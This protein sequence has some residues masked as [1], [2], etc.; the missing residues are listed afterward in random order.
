MY[1]SENWVELLIKQSVKQ[2]NQMD[3][4]LTESFFSNSVLFYLKQ[5]EELKMT[6]GEISSYMR[7]VTYKMITIHIN[8]DS[9]LCKC[10]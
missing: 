1:K 4:V 6:L 2:N 8:V 5:E 3:I 7:K 10:V 9:Y